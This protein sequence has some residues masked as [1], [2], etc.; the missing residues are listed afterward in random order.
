MKTLRWIGAAALAIPLLAAAAWASAPQEKKEAAAPGMDRSQYYEITIYMDSMDPKTEELAGKNSFRKLLKE[1]F[2]FGYKAVLYPGDV[3]EQLMLMLAAGNYP[4]IVRLYTSKAARAYGQAG[5]LVELGPLMDKYGPNFKARHESRIPAWKA[6]SGMNDGK[7]WLWTYWQPELSMGVSS[8]YLEWIIRS[9]ILEQQGYPNI[10]DEFD[11]Y[12]VLKKGVQANPTTDGYPTL[13]FTHPLAAWGTNGLYCIVMSFNLG[14]LHHMSL[15]HGSIYDFDQKKFIDVAT[16][17]SYKDG[18]K[19]FNLLYRDGLYDRE[20]VTDDYDAFTRKMESGRGLSNF[21]Y[22]WDY[23]GWNVALAQAGKPYRYIP[24]PLMLRSQREKGEYKGYTINS[25]EVWTSCAITKNAKSPERLME[26]LDWQATEEGLVACGWGM[27]G[28]QYA[29]RNGK[30][31][32]TQEHLDRLQKDSD[33]RFT[34]GGIMEL[35]FFGGLDANGQ[36]YLMDEDADYVA[37]SMDPVLKGVYAKYG[38]SGF[39]DMYR[40]NKNFKLIYDLPLDIKNAAPSFSYDQEKQWEKIDAMTH[41][42]TMKL[43][44]AR[45]EAEFESLFQAFLQRRNEMG[46]PALIAQWN[47]EYANLRMEY[48]LK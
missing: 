32:A 8:P 25:G 28:V 38:W 22:M 30:R 41:D 24:Y 19:F 36:C 20:A 35:G 31:Y 14:R 34:Y 48:G 23:R 16:D 10:K 43:V 4:D 21:F 40:Q 13:G 6:F 18:L 47:K 1:K 2:N 44:T 12:D 7:V 37:L 17:Y 29:V 27:E 33:Y 26:V 9:D 3:Q 11:M 42:Y 46:L 5:A 45:N 15:N 39:R